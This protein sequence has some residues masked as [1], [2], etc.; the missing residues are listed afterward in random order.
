MKFHLSKIWYFHQAE[1]PSSERHYWNMLISDKST[2][3]PLASVQ[4]KTE[5]AFK[6]YFKSTAS[7]ILEHY[8]Q[9]VSHL[10]NECFEKFLVVEIQG[11]SREADCFYVGNAVS[12][13]TINKSAVCKLIGV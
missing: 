4:M 11:G 3:G 9:C 6:L 12:N 5:I 8:L 2:S 1:E 13:V 7:W 10:I